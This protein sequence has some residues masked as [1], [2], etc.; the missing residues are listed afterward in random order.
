MA[1]I[2]GDLAELE[3]FVGGMLKSLEPKARRRLFRK[4]AT[5]MRRANQQRIRA[6]KNPDGSS[7]AKRKALPEPVPGNYAVKF[8]YP[9]GGS[10]TPRLVFMKSWEKQGPIFT[11]FDRE[12]GG[13]R[14]FEFAKVIKWLRVDA[15][16]DNAGGGKIRNRRKIR[17]RRMFR[18]IGRSGA[19]H[20]GQNDHEAWIGFAGS[21][22]A[23]A[24]VHQFGLRDRPARQSREVRY[25]RRELLGMTA[26]EREQLLDAVIEHLEGK[27]PT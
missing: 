17:D 16:D 12:A 7:F 22:A 6:Q 8:L 14:S 10:G 19:L 3:A 23:V 18:K 2:D 4:V 9:S 13:L 25:A 26:Q 1:E 15:R 21:V 20:T 24:T 11:G 5:G 27:S